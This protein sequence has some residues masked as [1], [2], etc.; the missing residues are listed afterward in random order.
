M[1][2]LVLLTTLTAMVFILLGKVVELAGLAYRF[3]SSSIRKR[4]VLSH[5]FSGQKSTFYEFKNHPQTM[6]RMNS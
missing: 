3:Q 1:T 4:R 5:F 2:L 6:A